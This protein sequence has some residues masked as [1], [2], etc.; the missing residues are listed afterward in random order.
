MKVFSTSQTRQWDQY[1]IAHQSIASIEL[2]EQAANAF[3]R[4]YCERFDNRTPVEIFCGM[5]NNGGDG[6]AIAR[7]L[8]NKH[9]SI[10]VFIVQHNEE[11]SVDFEQNL[12]RLGLSLTPTFI[13]D[14]DTVIPITSNS[15]VID[16]L[17]GSGLSRPATGIMASCINTINQTGATIIS[18]DIASGLYADK[19]NEAAD[20]I[21][22]P[23]YTVSFEVPKLV[24][25]LPQC[26]EY[27]GEW[28]VVDIGLDT[29]FLDNTT[30]LY[31]YI[32]PDSIC[33]IYK[34]RKKYAH[35]GTYGH[36]LLI[37]GSYGKIGAM[38]L[39]AKACLRAGVGLLTVQIPRCGYDILQTTLPEAMV[40]PDWHWSINTKLYDLSPYNAIGV[41]P[42]MGKEIHTVALLKDILEAIKTP[43]VL[44]ADAL[45]ILA[46]HA[47]MKQLIPKNT[48][49]TP[50][51]KEFERLLGQTWKDD[52]EKLELLRAFAQKHEIIVCLKGAHTAVA[53]PDGTI[54]FNSTG[55]PGMA[56][57]GSG[58]VLTGIITGLLAQGFSP[59]EAAIFGVYQHGTAGDRAAKKC[60]QPA[61]IASDIIENMGW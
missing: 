40:Q 13:K 38:V 56:T 46:E 9:Y 53:L 31:Y 7:L 49:L 52:F 48:I 24:F 61:L 37:G 6:L 45:N 34:K 42:G 47:D 14:T 18:V 59:Q 36:A 43:I 16:A 51:P 41:G 25:F 50:H 17:L 2:M 39:S 33:Y 1:T 27:V 28:H 23:T 60:T 29:S 22:K 21:I 44:D 15:I 8:L 10:K 32:T 19:P 55:N 26:A 11:G 57:A 35:K 3:V 4:W 20:T 54:Y 58:D 12:K 5:G 30:T